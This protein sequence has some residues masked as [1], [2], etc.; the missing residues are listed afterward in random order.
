MYVALYYLWSCVNSITTVDKPTQPLS[1]VL[2]ILLLLPRSN[3]NSL[4]LPTLLISL[5]SS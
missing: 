1:T 5:R 2:P 3:S 4:I